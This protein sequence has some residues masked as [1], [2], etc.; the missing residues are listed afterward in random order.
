MKKWF[1]KQTVTAF[2]LGAILFLSLPAFAESRTINGFFNNIRLKVNGEFI[3][4]DVEPFIV[5]GRTMVPA[6]FIA[7]PLGGSVKFNE[8]EN[9][10][11]IT[12]DKA[13]QNVISYSTG[14]KYVGEIKN[15]LPNGKGTLFWTDGSYYA[16]EMKDGAIQ[17][18]G[19]IKYSDGSML[20]GEWVNGEQYGYG[21]FLKSGDAIYFIKLDRGEIIQATKLQALNSST[22]QNNQSDSSAEIEYPLSLYSD[23]PKRIYLGKLVTN[24]FDTD[25]IYNQFGTYGSKFSGSSIWNEFGTYG[26]EFSKYSAFNQ[27]A[28]NPPLIIDN[29]GDIVGRLT[30]NEFTVGAIEPNSLYK[31]LKDLGQ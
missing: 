12:S 17:G 14:D 5:N 9:C 25:S 7:E 11:E 2:I 27:F 10:V 6:R 30:I 23:E 3:E 13:G 24:E 19:Y 20:F 21:Y 18:T 15:G 4:T 1:N 22:T 29:K 8:K 28:S 16:G 26:S 31:L